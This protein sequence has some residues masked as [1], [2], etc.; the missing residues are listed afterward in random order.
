MAK[1]GPK[2]GAYI[3]DLDGTLISLPVSWD[4]LREELRKVTGTRLEF[5]PFFKDVETVLS[6]HPDKRA[7]IF[8]LIDGYEVD[9][10]TWA[11]L[12][13]GAGEALASISSKVK[14]ALVTMQGR[15]ACDRV[16]DNLGLRPHFRSTFTREDSLDRAEQLKMAARSIAPYEGKL[17][18]VGD[19]INDL[20][21]ARKVGVGF[22][23]MRTL[24]DNPAADAVFRSM[25]DFRNSRWVTE[26][27][28][29]ENPG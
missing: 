19:R 10:L 8:A 5:R 11:K 23:M 24:P 2:I 7:E 4:E 22:V 1:S 12:N 20:V 25:R 28:A 16:L 17:V 26:L 9:A 14:V 6:Q 3:F 29:V 21:A 18:F 27:K 13:D 15:R